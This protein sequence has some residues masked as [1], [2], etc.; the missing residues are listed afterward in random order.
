MERKTNAWTI[1]Q[2]HGRSQLGENMGVVAEGGPQGL[3]CSAQEQALRT[4][5]ITLHTD[6]TSE[7]PICRMAF[8]K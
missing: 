5:C 8:L 7:S 4:N 6:K 1:C 2:G 3:I